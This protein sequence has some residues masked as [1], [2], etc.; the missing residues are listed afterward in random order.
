MGL[1]TAAFV[2]VYIFF[3]S[4]TYIAEIFHIGGPLHI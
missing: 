4:L 1:A 2:G 3:M